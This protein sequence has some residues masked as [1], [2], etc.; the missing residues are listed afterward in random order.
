MRQASVGGRRALII[1]GPTASGKSSLALE[2]AV[3]L[4][5]TVVNAD[6][7]QV[8][9]ELRILTARPS[10]AD[11]AAAPHVLYGVRPAA[12]P[13]S[14][15]WWRSEALTAMAGARL[16]ILCGGTGMYLQALTEGLADVPE[17]DPAAR[18]EARALLDQEGPG[19]LHERLAAVDPVTAAGLRPSDGQRLA[20]AWEVWRSTGQGLAAWQRSTGEKPP[21]HFRMILLEPPRDDLRDAIA[22]RFDA[23]LAAGGLD[24]VAAL[25]ALGLDPS[26]PAMRA[27]GVPELGA[28]LRGELELTEA[29]DRA[30]ASSRRYVKRQATWF[31]NRVIVDAAMKRIIHARFN[32]FEQLPES[33]RAEIEAFVS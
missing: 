25:A 18:D 29:R 23:M 7:M 4:G 12:E 21:Y 28:V 9:R 10:P 27:L 26:L 13:G 15:A 19:R 2:L 11:E 16:P 31:R 1:A 30:V 22:A 14:V 5:G 20:R 6:S 8:Y 17:P 24:E 32:D 33:D 3:R